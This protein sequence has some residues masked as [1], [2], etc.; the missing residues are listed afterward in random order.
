MEN[1]LKT[2]MMIIATSEKRVLESAADILR[3]TILESSKSNASHTWP[4]S[5]EYLDSAPWPDELSNFLHKLLIAK[6]TNTVSQK[7]Q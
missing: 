7:T 6:T 4:P 1:G 3:R 2:K 5:H